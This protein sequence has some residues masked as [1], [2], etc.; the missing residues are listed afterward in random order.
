MMRIASTGNISAVVG[1]FINDYDSGDYNA[2]WSGYTP[3][4]GINGLCVVAHNTN[5]AGSDR[6]Y[7]Y[8]GGAWKYAA[9][10]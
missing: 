9:L 1:G 6:A 5:G 4:S 8:S 7:F 2:D 10:S 3:P